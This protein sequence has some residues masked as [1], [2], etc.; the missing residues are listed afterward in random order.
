MTGEGWD[1]SR[2]VLSSV[3]SDSSS[4]GSVS[5][6]EETVFSTRVADTGMYE[7]DL[8]E[9]TGVG[10]IS[11]SSSDMI[12]TGLFGFDILCHIR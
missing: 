11:M 4:D 6:L 7:G 3:G 8:G 5:S 10:A 2:S 1:S 9:V 12:W